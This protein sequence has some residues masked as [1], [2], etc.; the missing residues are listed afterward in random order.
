LAK[1]DVWHLERAVT[2]YANV[3][4]VFDEV[5]ER[6]DSTLSESILFGRCLIPTSWFGAAGRTAGEIAENEKEFFEMAVAPERTDTDIETEV[7]TD[8]PA[9]RRCLMCGSMFPSEWRGERVC[10]RCKGRAAWREGS[11]WS[12]GSARTGSSR[13]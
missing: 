5:A 2:I 10:R 4:R 8:A 1:D 11:Q 12:S 13:G 3:T 6:K 7:V 9:E